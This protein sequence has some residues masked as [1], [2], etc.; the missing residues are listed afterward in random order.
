MYGAQQGTQNLPKKRLVL[1]NLFFLKEEKKCN[2]G[3]ERFGSGGEK[4]QNRH[5]RKIEKNT[6][7]VPSVF[8]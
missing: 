8:N 3:R 2:Q 1:V 4:K 5:E 7:I 6:I